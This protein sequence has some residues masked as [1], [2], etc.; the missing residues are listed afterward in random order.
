MIF[1]LK[2]TLILIK[3]NPGT[4]YLWG[5]GGGC[6][7]HLIRCADNVL[8][9]IL[10]TISVYRTFPQRQAVT[11]TWKCHISTCLHLIYEHTL[12]KLPLKAL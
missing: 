1:F 3:R 11:V 6:L 5:G 4:E 7:V 10:H 9:Q 12:G 2:C 8:Q